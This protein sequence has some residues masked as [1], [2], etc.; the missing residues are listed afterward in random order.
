LQLRQRG[1]RLATGMSPIV[2]ERR[3][4]SRPRLVELRSR[5]NHGLTPVV[6]AS[7]LSA[8]TTV[9]AFSP[10]D[11]YVKIPALPPYPGA[12]GPSGQAVRRCPDEPDEA[13][14]HGAPGVQ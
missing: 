12:R 4:G 8:G 6:V 1:N 14:G 7:H 3:S 10:L 11:A 2:C 9:T 5:P 13:R